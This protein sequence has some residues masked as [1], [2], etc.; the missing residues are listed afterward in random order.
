MD[1]KKCSKCKNTYGTISLYSLWW[2]CDNPKDRH[3]FT[4]ISRNS[5]EVPEYCPYYKETL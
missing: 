2:Y 5:T 4:V 3:D 1:N